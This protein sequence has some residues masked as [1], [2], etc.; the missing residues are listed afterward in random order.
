[1]FGRSCGL[2][3]EWKSILAA[4]ASGK[5]SSTDRTHKVYFHSNVIYCYSS[6]LRNQRLFI[7]SRLLNVFVKM[8]CVSNLPWIL[9][10]HPSTPT[11]N[12]NNNPN[13]IHPVQVPLNSSTLRTCPIVLA[14]VQAHQGRWCSLW[15][16]KTIQW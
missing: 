9:I 4:N 15:V 6:I 8:E 5:C 14:V 3:F 2:V 1:M 13:T 16:S 10:Q 12:R 7:C 11:R